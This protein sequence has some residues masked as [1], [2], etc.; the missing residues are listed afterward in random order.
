M[1]QHL[2]QGL[3]NVTRASLT[4]THCRMP[5][6]DRCRT[7]GAVVYRYVP[8]LLPSLHP[9]S[10]HSLFISTGD[11]PPRVS[12][13]QVLCGWSECDGSKEKKC[14]GEEIESCSGSKPNKLCWKAVLFLTSPFFL[15]PGGALPASTCSA[16]MPLCLPWTIN[17]CHADYLLRQRGR[18]RGQGGW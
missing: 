17:M 13:T 8:S 6:S 4:V 5:G 9:P 15:A 10:S 7:K 1:T 14:S 3:L 18:Q 11:R 16:E 2:C 12:V